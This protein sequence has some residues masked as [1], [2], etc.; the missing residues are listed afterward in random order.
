MRCSVGVHGWIIQHTSSCVIEHL[1]KPKEQMSKSSIEYTKARE[2]KLQKKHV[3]KYKRTITF[4]SEVLV[5]TNHTTSIM[6]KL[7]I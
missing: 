4:Q 3:P 7:D 1:I 5:V 6:E 2:T